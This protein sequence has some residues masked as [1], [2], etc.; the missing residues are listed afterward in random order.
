MDSGGIC[1]PADEN[2]TGT[3]VVDIAP[4]GTERTPNP[5]GYIVAEDAAGV[6]FCA[7]PAAGTSSYCARHRLLCQVTPDSPEGQAIAAELAAEAERAPLPG[8]P[9]IPVLE[10]DDPEPGD[11]LAAL[12]LKRQE[13][14]EEPAEDAT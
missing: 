2:I 7:A 9:S 11:A 3:S 13:A 12:D 4:A 5:C 6:V 1:A 14:A 10:P 8:L